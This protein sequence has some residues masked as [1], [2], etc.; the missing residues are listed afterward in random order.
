MRIARGL[1]AMCLLIIFMVVAY[2]VLVIRP[3]SDQDLVPTARYYTESSI[4]LTQ[5][6]W[7]V[8]VVSVLIQVPGNLH[9]LMC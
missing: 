2:D 4:S 5:M 7:N 6:P 1:S 8:L 9:H 3:F